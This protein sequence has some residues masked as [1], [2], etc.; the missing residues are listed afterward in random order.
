MIHVFR[1]FLPL[2][3]G[4]LGGLLGSLFGL[5]LHQLLCR[6]L[7][8]L[9]APW[10]TWHWTIGLLAYSLLG[11]LLALPFLSVYPGQRMGLRSELGRAQDAHLRTWIALLFASYLPIGVGVL[12]QHWWGAPAIAI[13]FTDTYLYAGS[14]GDLLSGLAAIAIIGSFCGIG[15]ERVSRGLPRAVRVLFGPPAAV[16]LT[17]AGVLAVVLSTAG[18]VGGGTD[19]APL[20]PLLQPLSQAGW[21]SNLIIALLTVVS[22]CIAGTLSVLTVALPVLSGLPD[23]HPARSRRRWTLPL[24]GVA[25]SGAIAV[26]ALVQGYGVD[27][28]TWFRGTIRQGQQAV[29]GCLVAPADVDVYG[30]DISQEGFYVFEFPSPEVNG[31][32][33]LVVPGQL[34]PTARNDRVR[35]LIEGTDYAYMTEIQLSPSWPPRIGVSP[36]SGPV[37]LARARDGELRRSGRGAALLDVA[38]GDLIHWSA[39]LKEGQADLVLRTQQAAYWTVL[40]PRSDYEVAWTWDPG[41]SMVTLRGLSDGRQVIGQVL[42]AEGYG[43]TALNVLVASAHAGIDPP[44]LRWLLTPSRPPQGS[45][46]VPIVAEGRGPDA[47]RVHPSGGL[48]IL[49]ARAG[50]AFSVHPQPGGTLTVA[51][52]VTRSA[53]TPGLERRLDDGSWEEI[54]GDLLLLGETR[55]RVSGLEPGVAAVVVLGQEPG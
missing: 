52:V 14:R 16:V 11:F 51:R 17:M 27:S 10:P 36:Y 2:V 8:N 25:V 28:V 15:V 31:R 5:G 46:R 6:A 22:G 48:S 47:D 4:P 13:P 42:D 53:G 39:D 54:T 7:R 35:Y 26:V 21:D 29:V 32:H 44:E 30:L 45:L 55:L 37:R 19:V 38:P 9:W 12:Y 3:L 50:Q 18:I 20:G 34:L 41:W 40:G 1:R 43:A 33:Q 49:S 24:L 23:V